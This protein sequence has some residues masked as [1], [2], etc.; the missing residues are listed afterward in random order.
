[1]ERE[2]RGASLHTRLTRA[3][4]RGARAQENSR[5]LISD[6]AALRER[7]A[8]TLASI[9]ARRER[10]GDGEPRRP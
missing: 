10:D 6:H 4:A 7:V 5:S 8:A 1:M 9:A 2:G 3:L